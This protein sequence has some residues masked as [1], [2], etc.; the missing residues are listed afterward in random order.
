MR[1]GVLFPLLSFCVLALAVLWL[2]FGN[3]RLHP[4]ASLDVATTAQ[5][6]AIG[7]AEQ[8]ELSSSVPQQLAMGDDFMVAL[9]DG[10]VFTKGQNGHGQLGNGDIGGSSDLLAEVSFSQDVTISKIDATESHVL[11]LDHVGRVWAW[12]ANLSGQIG[13]GTRNDASSPLLVFE[14]ARSIAA[15][16]RFSAVVDDAG[17]LW[18]WGMSCEQTSEVE[19][20]VDSFSQD[21]SVGGAYY[22]G[23]DHVDNLQHCLNEDNLPIGSLDPVRIEADARFASVAGGY[24]H[25]LMLDENGEVWSFGCNAWGQLGRGST[26]HPPEFRK[27]G[28][29]S[30]GDNA[31]KIVTIDAGFRHSAALDSSGRAWTWGWQAAGSQT[32]AGSSSIDSPQLLALG[33]DVVEL[34]AG[35]DLTAFIGADESL[36]AYGV[37]QNQRI[38]NELPLT[39]VNVVDPRNIAED[40]VGVGTTRD[41]LLYWSRHE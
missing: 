12:G 29:I 39:D 3:T 36:L 19:Q 14:G 38:T 33:I 25:L 37:N 24:G 17:E 10:R 30:F 6:S 35:H 27:P 20:L 26:E 5:V 18:A 34:E 23:G 41:N 8:P 40:V 9:V 32:S 16:Y 21:V 7:F 22:D 1:R 31:P 13:D 15:G 4:V 11:A 28:K 2:N